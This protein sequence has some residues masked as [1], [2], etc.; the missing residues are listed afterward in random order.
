M[1]HRVRGEYRYQQDPRHRDDDQDR[2]RDVP[3]VSAQ[4][5]TPPHINSGGPD[6]GH[7]P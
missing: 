6:P 7:Q 5:T 1:M 3:L 2:E 4:G